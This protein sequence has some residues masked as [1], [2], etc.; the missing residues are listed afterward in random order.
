MIHPLAQRISNPSQPTP[1]P[2]SSI[3]K[4]LPPTL[5]VAKSDMSC[6]FS[7][8]ILTRAERDAI[9]RLREKRAAGQAPV[10]TTHRAPHHSHPDPIVTFYRKLP[11]PKPISRQPR[12]QHRPVNT[13]HTTTRK[14]SKTAHQQKKQVRQAAKRKRVEDD[15]DT[16]EKI[17]PV[18]VF[19]DKVKNVNMFQRSETQDTTTEGAS[20]DKENSV[21]RLM[22]ATKKRLDHVKHRFGNQS[23]AGE[24]FV[25]QQSPNADLSECNNDHYFQELMKSDA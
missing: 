2:D 8:H 24:R 17:P 23:P 20:S 7:S 16:S 14:P 15:G 6:C 25:L 10:A 4:T 5:R 18:R 12:Q 21:N 19:V 13:Q 22:A 1:Q 11:S 3:I 9:A